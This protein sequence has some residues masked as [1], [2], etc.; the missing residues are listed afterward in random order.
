MIISFDNNENKVCS[1][2]K[3]NVGRSRIR[4]CAR[5]YDLGSCDHAVTKTT[6]HSG[7]MEAISELLELVEL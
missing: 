4:S 6:P 3:N 2:L 7:G 1:L 5:S